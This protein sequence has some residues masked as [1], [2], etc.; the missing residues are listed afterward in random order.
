[1]KLYNKNSQQKNNASFN[2]QRFKNNKLRSLFSFLLAIENCF[3]VPQENLKIYGSILIG[4][5][6]PEESPKTNDPWSLQRVSRTVQ[7][8]HCITQRLIQSLQGPS[9]LMAL[10][11]LLTHQRILIG[12]LSPCRY[13]QALQPLPMHISQRVA[14][15]S[16]AY[17]ACVMWT[18]PLSVYKQLSIP[19]QTNFFG[20]FHS[21]LILFRTPVPKIEFGP[22]ILSGD[23][24]PEDPH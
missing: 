1:M 3:G 6:D 10:K 19:Q 2:P 7:P 8:Q 11:S 13:L 17:H 12:A 23:Y 9:H 21:S 5:D 4:L 22:H 14:R 15:L 24:S 18:L 20:T 16:P